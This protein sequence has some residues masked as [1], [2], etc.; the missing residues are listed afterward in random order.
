MKSGDQWKP[1]KS[2]PWIG[3]PK[4]AVQMRVPTRRHLHLQ[5]S[6]YLFPAVMA[7]LLADLILQCPS[8]KLNAPPK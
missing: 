1:L 8:Y 4:D 6:R 7:P 3:S 5:T 2:K